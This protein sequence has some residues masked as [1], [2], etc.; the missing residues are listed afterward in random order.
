MLLIACNHD[1]RWSKKS[2]KKGPNQGYYKFY[3]KQ[4]KTI[5]LNIQENIETI[6]LRCFQEAAIW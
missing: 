3:I 5:K 2:K 4:E 1:E 6:L